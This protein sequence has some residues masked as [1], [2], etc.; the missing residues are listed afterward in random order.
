[1]KNI[2][3]ETVYVSLNLGKI[4]LTPPNTRKEK[5]LLLVLMTL[6]FMLFFGPLT[7][8]A[9]N[10]VHAVLISAVPTVTTS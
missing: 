1:M 6:F 4:F 10:P 3:Q 7:F 2:K 5:I 9:I 8:S